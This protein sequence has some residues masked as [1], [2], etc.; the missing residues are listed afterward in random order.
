MFGKI[1]RLLAVGAVGQRLGDYVKR[2]TTKYLVLSAAGMIFLI[3]IVFGIL[4]IFWALTSST[5]DPVLSAGIM[6]GALALIGLLTALIAYGITGR[7]PS[8]AK[9]TLTNPVQ[10]AQ[11]QIPSVED[12]GRQIGYAVRQYG[13]MRVTAAAAA[14]GLAAGILAKRFGQLPGS[15]PPRFE[16]GPPLPR[17]RRQRAV[18]SRNSAR[19]RW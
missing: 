2:L 6:A 16:D 4:A 10:A 18:R 12:V 1:P 13:P 17:A 5:R 9:Q 7:R 14:G 3:A 19:A 11:G 15:P 8:S